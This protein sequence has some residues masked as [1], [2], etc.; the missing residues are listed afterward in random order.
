MTE[1]Q[2]GVKISVKIR[3]SNLRWH[4]QVVVQ[5]VHLGNSA[6]QFQTDGPAMQLTG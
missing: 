6:R 2:T 4:L 3:N 5:L 1:R